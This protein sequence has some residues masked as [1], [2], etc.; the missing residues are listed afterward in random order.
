ME[1]HDKRRRRPT[2]RS[3]ARMADVSPSTVSRALSG[4]E[5]VS[6]STRAHIIRLAQKTG[7]IVSGPGGAGAPGAGGVSEPVEG[8][9]DLGRDVT[10][11][12]L[13]D[14]RGNPCLADL[15]ESAFFMELI[16]G[17]SAAARDFGA[18]LHMARVDEDGDL[19][20]AIANLD[21]DAGRSSGVI[22]LGY[23]PGT[24]YRP[25][26]EAFE[27][28]KTPIV[29]CDH[30]VAELGYDAVL[31]DNIGGSFAVANH[32]ADLG[33]RR[34][35]ILQQALPSVAAVQRTRGFRAGLLE[36]GVPARGIAVVEAPPSF[37]GGYDAADALIDAGVTAIACGND[38]MAL[39]V[40]R[41]AYER[42]VDVP[43]ELSVS[44]FDDIA[45]SAQIAPALT[46]VRVDK[47]AIGY[48]SVRRLL[49]RIREQRA[50]IQR[51]ALSDGGGSTPIRSIVPTELVVREST[52][53]APA[54]E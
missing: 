37:D 39:G 54:R 41:R 5:G 11:A 28:R 45:S 36:R 1:R 3:L 38:V 32:L 34:V 49:A 6:E 40:L 33:H 27:M 29:L 52:G 21:A 35:A 18:T 50:G 53:P 44:G 48:E 19:Q 13:V 8:Y 47:R 43:G 42:G 4:K 14:A 10:I 2:V 26:I 15:T 16:G 7:L 23:Q 20:A 22:W 9:A 25:W 17:I 31:S 30:Y 24:L 12:L 51:G 46:T